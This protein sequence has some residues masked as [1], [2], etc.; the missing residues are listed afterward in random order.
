MQACD[1]IL[2][3]VVATLPVLVAPE[4]VLQVLGV[5]VV[6]SEG[7]FALDPVD[8][9][10]IDSYWNLQLEVWSLVVATPTQGMLI[11]HA[12]KVELYYTLCWYRSI[13]VKPAHMR[14]RV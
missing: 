11:C 13:V 4:L 6:I 3:Y 12:N 5:G 1:L 9:V 2:H 10:T 14:M 8:D 7:C